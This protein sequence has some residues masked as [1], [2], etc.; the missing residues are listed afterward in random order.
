M[1][2][3]CSRNSLLYIYQLIEHTTLIALQVCLRR[4]IR[5]DAHDKG[6]AF[7]NQCS[8][9]MYV[10]KASMTVDCK[11]SILHAC[12]SD[13]SIYSSDHR[14]Y[15]TFSFA[16]DPHWIG[17]KRTFPSKTKELRYETLSFRISLLDLRCL[18]L[19]YWIEA[20]EHFVLA[21]LTVA[22]IDQ[23]IE[24]ITLPTL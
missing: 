1:L 18:R 9:Y 13:C 17:Q 19:L 4:E 3:C 22:F 24:P 10:M 6:L 7:H 5:V 12:C 11:L 8:S 16:K 20:S 2:D 21:I 23:V 14:A 15:H